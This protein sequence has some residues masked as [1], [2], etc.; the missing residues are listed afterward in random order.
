MGHAVVGGCPVS[1]GTER[2]KFPLGHPTSYLIVIQFHVVLMLDFARHMQVWNG[3]DHGLP[4]LKLI[5]CAV[6]KY[7]G[8]QVRNPTVTQ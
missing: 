7:G 4:K 2:Q 8:E 5:R 1:G 3:L 6:K